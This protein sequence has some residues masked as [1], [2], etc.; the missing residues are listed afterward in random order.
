[1]AAAAGA[2]PGGRKRGH[3]G[4]KTLPLPC[5]SAAFVAKTVPFFAAPQEGGA[6]PA[7]ASQ[8]EQAVAK[9]IGK[10]IFRTFGAEVRRCTSPMLPN[11]FCSHEVRD[12]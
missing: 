11:R 9:Q 7:G 5:A 4:G 6:A 10:D 8:S 12:G 2:K 3:A 1:M